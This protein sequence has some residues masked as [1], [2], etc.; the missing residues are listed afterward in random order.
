MTA[1]RQTTAGYNR[2]TATA[3][4]PAVFEWRSLLPY[5]DSGKLFDVMIT[6]ATRLNVL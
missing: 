1:G 4:R 3:H 5:G 2:A 6:G